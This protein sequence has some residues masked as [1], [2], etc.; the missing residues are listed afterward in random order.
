MDHVHSALPPLGR[1]LAALRRDSGPE[2]A[3]HFAPRAGLSY[4]HLL[5]ADTD[6]LNEVLTVHVLDHAREGLGIL[7]HQRGLSVDREQ[8]GAP[9]LLKARH[10]RLGLPLKLRHGSHV[11]TLEHG[12]SSFL[13]RRH[14]PANKQCISCW[15]MGQAF[16]ANGFIRKPPCEAP[17]PSPRTP[18]SVPPSAAPS[19]P[20]PPPGTCPAGT[21]ASPHPSPTRRAPRTPRPRLSSRSCTPCAGRCPS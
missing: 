21:G 19:P 3:L 6:R 16:A 12:W 8:F 4:L 7:N 11:G 9:G 10:G 14:I 15:L 13:L 5:D 17:R 2:V 18:P 20:A 1:A